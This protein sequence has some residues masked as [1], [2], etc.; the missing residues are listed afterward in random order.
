MP[1]LARIQPMDFVATKNVFISAIRFA[2]KVD[3]PCP[4]FRDELRISAQEQVE[5][6]LGNDED[7]LLVADDEVKSETRTGLFKAFSLFESELSSMDGPPNICEAAED[8][9]IQ[10]LSDLE[11]MCGILLKM[12]LMDDFVSKWID[13]SESVLLVFD[14]EKL[15]CVMWG[16]K[17]KLI[18]VTS[19]VLDAA[20]YGNVI[21]PASRRVWL[22]KTWLPFIRKLK[23]LLDSMND[24]DIE[25]SY[26][27]D[28]DLWQ[29][30]EGAIVSLVSALPSDDQAEILADWMSADDQLRYP[31]LSEA[32]EVWCFR[33]KSAKRRL[34]GGLDEVNTT[35]SL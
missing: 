30:V 10:C 20:G 28:E 27:M 23:P 17:V 6:M 32:F 14:D 8:R 5:Y 29:S 31:D 3:G 35:A 26:K 16:L 4:P 15:G 7:M 24:R 21:L 18:Q 19:K 11:W 2:T 9:I 1:V 12:G 13:V 33:T 22:L 25:F 34:V